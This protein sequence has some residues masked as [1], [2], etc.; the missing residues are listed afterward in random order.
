MNTY[1][2]TIALSFIVLGVISVIVFWKQSILLALLL[3]LL[4]FIKQKM[5]PIKGAF[6]WFIIIGALGSTMEGVI[7]WLG[8][9]PWTYASPF[10]FDVPVWL[11]PLYG[12]AGVV[13][14]TL[15]EGVFRLK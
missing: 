1:K 8:G 3:V 9:N 7:I 6:V 15:Y 10:M 2:V 12:L 4:A 11:F 13:F 5:S 14:I